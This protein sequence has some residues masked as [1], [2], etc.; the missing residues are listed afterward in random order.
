MEKTEK[1]LQQYL[2]AYF[3][4]ENE[5][6]EWKEFSSMKNQF[7]GKEGDD[8]VSYVSALANMEGGSLVMGIKDKTLDIVGIDNYNYDQEKVRLRLKDQ[9]TN[10]PIEDVKLTEFRTSDTDKLVWV[11]TVPKHSFRLPVYAHSKAWQRIDDSL[12]ELTPS[13]LQA[14]LEELPNI[15]DW[16]AEIVPDAT[17]KDLDD[18]ALAKARIQYAK[19]HSRIGKETIDSWPIEDFLAYSGVMVDGQLTRAALLLLGTP[20]SA[21]KLRPAVAEVTWILKNPDGTTKDY[22]HFGPPF[23]LTVDDIL[24]KIRNIT[25][26][27]LTGGTL[28]PDTMQQYDDYTIRELLHNCIAH[29]DYTLQQRVNFVEREGSLY[30]ENGAVFLP[31]NIER[32]IEGKAPQRYYRNH[33]LCDAMA[34]FNMIDKVGRGI[35]EVYRKQKERHFPMP[36]YEINKDEQTVSVTVYGKVIDEAYTNMLLRNTDLSLKDCILLDA[37][38]KKRKITEDALKYLRKKGLIEGRRPN[39][40]ISK[41]IAKATGQ[42]ADYSRNK[43]F[44]E[45][46]YEALII[47]ALEHHGELTKEKI[48]ELLYDLLPKGYTLDQKRNRVDY[49]LK[50]LRTAKRITYN[51]ETKQWK[52]VK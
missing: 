11:L 7:C 16:S 13:R 35:Q 26:R 47:N 10:I 23:I 41:R 28:F 40:L 29:Q 15:K 43:G 25:M 20:M 27:E 45:E 52:L 1:E 2:L 31:G 48:K 51:A 38:Q 17:L 36:D 6:C 37:V 30:Y 3:P 50:K 46:K 19:V 32:V 24:K 18:M 33:C 8:V 12:V 9:C 34:H 21:V 42:Q 44:E 14:I 22:E 5:S 49:S 4:R 39:V